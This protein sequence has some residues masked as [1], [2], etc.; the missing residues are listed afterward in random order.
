MSKANTVINILKVHALFLIVFYFIYLIGIKTDKKSWSG[1]DKM[2][3]NEWLHA[4]YFTV[5]THT[6]VG[7]GDVYPKATLWRMIISLHIICVYIL[8]IIGIKYL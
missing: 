8:T 7:F 3:G 6:T 2:H 4:F 5:T 1:I